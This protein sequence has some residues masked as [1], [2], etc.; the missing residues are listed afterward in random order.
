MQRKESGDS[1]GME[2]W[3]VSRPT[4]H[5]GREGWGTRA[6][7]DARQGLGVA[8]PVVHEVLNSPGRPLDGTMRSFMEP[9]FGHD[10]SGVRIHT[11][12][13]A[14]ESARSVNAL[15]Y[16]VGRNI[17]FASGQYSPGSPAGQR[18]LAHELTHVVQQQQWGGPGTL[19]ASSSSPVIAAENSPAEHEADAL[20]H[21]VMAGQSV[22]G[23]KLAAPAGRMHRSMTNRARIAANYRL[24]L[25]ELTMERHGWICT[26]RGGPGCGPNISGTS[27]PAQTLVN[28]C[29]ETSAPFVR[30]EKTV[31]HEVVHCTGIGSLRV[32]SE[33]YWFQPGYPG[34]DPLHNADSYA[35]FPMAAA[36]W[37]ML[38]PTP[39]TPTPA[40]PP[41][42]TPPPPGS[43]APSS[44]STP[45]PVLQRTPNRAVK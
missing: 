5:K 4:L 32:G 6:G 12:P 27:S 34:S 42:T 7:A 33:T 25:S 29:I 20:A 13:R 45:P 39:V 17:V 3:A 9:R 28:L 1:A 22:A 41:T 18:L 30:S 35:Q 43:P 10:F 14:A 15:A 31:L 44:T 2:T 24:I 11:D 26:P 40:T 38:H 37:V 23:R 8:P 19:A 36:T 21:R 16:T